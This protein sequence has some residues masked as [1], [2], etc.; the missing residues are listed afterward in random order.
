MIAA[1]FALPVHLRRVEQLA[2][3]PAADD[4]FFTRH[5]NLEPIIVDVQDVANVQIKT[6][7]MVGSVVVAD[8][9]ARN[10]GEVEAGLPPDQLRQTA[11]EWRRAMPDRGEVHI[12]PLLHKAN[13]A[14]RQ[15]FEVVRH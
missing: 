2:G 1:P 14:A 10:Y 9:D 4:A 13:A 12:R 8:A 6:V 15:Q 7:R 3:W 5:Q 11:G